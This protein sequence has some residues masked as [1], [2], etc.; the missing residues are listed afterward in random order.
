MTVLELA[1]WDAVWQRWYERS[2]VLGLSPNKA[3][4]RA[5]DEMDTRYGQRPTEETQ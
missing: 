4:V 5:D 1:A 3:I 2:V